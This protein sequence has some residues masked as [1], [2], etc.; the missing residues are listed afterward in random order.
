MS[1]IKKR[2]FLWVQILL[3]MFL[4]SCNSNE[5]SQE[6]SSLRLNECIEIILSPTDYK[7]FLDNELSL[8]PYQDIIE[9]CVNSD[10]EKNLVSSEPQ[11]ST[12]T[13]PTS[14]STSTS[15]STTL[16]KQ[17][18]NG[19]SEEALN[20]SEKWPMVYLFNSL[21]DSSEAYKVAKTSTTLEASRVDQLKLVF[22]SCNSNIVVLENTSLIQT[23]EVSF[24]NENC[25]NGTSINSFKYLQISNLNYEI[26]LFKE[27]QYENITT[28]EKGCCHTLNLKDL[29]NQ[30]TSIINTFFATTTT[31]TTTIPYP[32]TAEIESCIKT[33]EN[34]VTISF[35]FVV[36]AP[37]S[38]VTSIR[39]KTFL[40]GSLST[41]E[42]FENNPNIELTPKNSSSRYVYDFVIPNKADLES[43]LFEVYV[44]NERGQDITVQ[45]GFN[46]FV[47]DRSPPGPFGTVLLTPREMDLGDAYS[48]ATFRAT[49]QLKN[50]DKIKRFTY[51]LISNEFNELLFSCEISFTN[52][53]E[54]AANTELYCYKSS[55]RL[56]SSDI[57]SYV[58]YSLRGDEG[59]SNR[60]VGWYRLE[61]EVEDMAGN[62]GRY[63]SCKALRVYEYW[64][65]YPTYSMTSLNQD[66]GS[67]G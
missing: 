14:T 22:S 19:F 18:I 52:G 21:T 6:V 36:N 25:P 46:I 2:N 26:R 39:V 13:I 61:L 53:R 51:K 43:G 9:N 47:P 20:A 3:L 67:C 8:E 60:N 64:P 35:P 65:R 62:I 28:G 34:N 48:R 55:M 17:K 7:K 32:P 23:E 40:N 12:E 50:A 58:D 41:E 4:L 57:P 49:T 30:H 63:V 56:S 37:S 66:Y 45:C 5:G 42:F 1:F 15:T 54:L 16:V 24:I 27:G 44:L 29:V 10:M 31:T 33:T 38:K 59:L 11:E